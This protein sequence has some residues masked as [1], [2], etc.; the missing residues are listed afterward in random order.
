MFRPQS[1]APSAPARTHPK[2]SASARAR[3]PAQFK[4]KYGNIA[5][6][7]GP[8][9]AAHLMK[10]GEKKYFD[11]ADWA[12]DVAE[13]QARPGGG[14]PD[15]PG[16]APSVPASSADTAVHPPPPQLRQQPS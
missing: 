16:S 9:L 8:G 7:T 13:Q 1:R 3:N 2:L 10:G 15:A 6:K 11:S 4:A 12:K 14:D 5:K